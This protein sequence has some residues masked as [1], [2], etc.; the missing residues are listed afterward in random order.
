MTNPAV[1]GA[2]VVD[3]LVPPAADAPPPVRRRRSRGQVGRRVVLLVAAVYFIG[4]LVAAI[5]FTV[6]N[7]HGGITFSAYRQIFTNPGDGQINLVQALV[8]SLEI[9]V[10]TIVVALALMVP[11]QLLL[12]LRV[13]R[14]RGSVEILTLL[15]LVFPP[16]VLVVGVSDVY[17]A[18][19]PSSGAAA[20]HDEGFAFQVLRFLRDTDH[21]LLL[22]LLYVMLAMPFVYRAIDAGIRAID[23]A[24]LVEA[25]RNLGASWPSVLLRV[26]VPCL[27]TSL[28]NAS[29]LCFALVMGEYTIS[30]ILL[31]TKPFPVWLAQL[32]T[33][34]GQVQAAV[35]V[36]SLLLVEVILL[37]IGA[38]TAR[39]K[40][41]A[42]A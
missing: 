32:P 3:T 2:A 17:Q 15:P 21:P 23:V 29:F 8:Y 27:R 38:I 22:A 12:H 42:T 13:P 41:G 30:S 24:T 7:P 11:T 35:S 5:S 39:G 28:I 20:G 19:A 25:A 40:R 26:I 9:A 36:F 18:A 33:R 14:M 16:V 1:S 31:Y 6:Q 34:S 10:V 37:A 4:P